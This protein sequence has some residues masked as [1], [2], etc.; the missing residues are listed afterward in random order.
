MEPIKNELMSNAELRPSRINYPIVYADE[1]WMQCSINITY[2]KEHYWVS[3]YGRIYSSKLNAII[4]PGMD[5]SGYLRINLFAKDGREVRRSI[6]RLVMESFCWFEG[7]DK[8]QVNHINGIKIDNY[9]GNLEWTTRSENMRHAYLTGLNHSGEDC[10]LSK[11]SNQTIIRIADLLMQDTLSYSQ[12]CMEV[13]GECNDGYLHLV[14]NIA[15]K[16]SWNIL[17]Q[18]Y[19]FPKYRTHKQ[20]LSDDKLHRIYQ[21]HLENP[22]LIGSDIARIFVQDFDSLPSKDKSRYVRAIN[23]LIRKEA[24]DHIYSCYI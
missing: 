21:Y 1:L 17:L 11:Y 13:F 6:H 10:L 22:M 5:M 8:Y 15:N 3:N 24:Y 2:L 18:N 14:S 9:I 19:N 20:V 7:C 12:I 23:M 16:N 4:N